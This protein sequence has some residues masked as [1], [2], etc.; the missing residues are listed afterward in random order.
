MSRIF[1]SFDQ[2]DKT[3][4]GA[5]QVDEAVYEGLKKRYAEEVCGAYKALVEDIL[6]TVEPRG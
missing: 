3:Y 1:A 6:A 2:F 5:F 4:R